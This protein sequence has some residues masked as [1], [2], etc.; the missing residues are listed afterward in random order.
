MIPYQINLGNVKKYNKNHKNHK[1]HYILSLCL[2]FSSH[3]PKYDYFFKDK[4]KELRFYQDYSI[5]EDFNLDN[6]DVHKEIE[7]VYSDI[8]EK[9]IISI[10]D[11]N[12]YGFFTGNENIINYDNLDLI[13][14][15]FKKSEFN[16]SYTLHLYY[17]NIISSSFSLLHSISG[18]SEICITKLKNQYYYHKRYCYNGDILN[19]NK[20]CKIPEVL[21]YQRINKLTKLKDEKEN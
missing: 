3:D 14:N 1:N 15:L 18:P 2:G 20:W 12:K 5:I 13:I 16:L 11:F 21:K 10:D 17:C 7:I 4:Y 19:E 8:I 6:I 9:N